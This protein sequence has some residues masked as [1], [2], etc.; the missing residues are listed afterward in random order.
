MQKKQRLLQNKRFFCLITMASHVWGAIVFL[1]KRRSRVVF[2]QVC[3]DKFRINKENNIYQKAC[4]Y[5]GGVLQ[6]RTVKKANRS[7]SVALAGAG[8]DVLRA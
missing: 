4:F 6:K 8:R 1:F 3:A 2:E 5:D 7:G